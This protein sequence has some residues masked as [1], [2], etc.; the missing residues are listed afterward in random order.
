MQLTLRERMR[1]RYCEKS[2]V[3]LRLDLLLIS[4][5]LLI[6]LEREDTVSREESSKI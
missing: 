5:R 3:Y 2:R 1:K 6:S 4:T